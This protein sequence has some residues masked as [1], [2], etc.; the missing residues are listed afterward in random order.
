KVPALHDAGGAAALG[1]AND[2]DSGDVLEDINGKRIA[3][4]LRRRVLQANFTDETLGLAIGLGQQRHAGRLPRL[5]P[6]RLDLGDVAA[7]RANRITARLVH[8]AK[9]EGRIAILLFVFD[10]QHSAGAAFEDG[11]GYRQ[12]L[13]VVDLGHP[14]LAAQKAKAHDK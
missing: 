14:D 7:L 9:L 13:V 8:V 11:D 10:L 2:I 6:L 5:V 3:D 12:T 1:L 4:F